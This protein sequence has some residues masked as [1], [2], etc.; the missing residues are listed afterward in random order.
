MQGTVEQ[1]HIEARLATLERRFEQLVGPL[2]P[3]A[4][5]VDAAARAQAQPPAG[6]YP[7]SGP[8]PARSARTQDP[9]RVGA[10]SRPAPA[11]LKAGVATPAA[12]PVFRD[13]AA[14]NESLSDL[15]GGR[16][17]A[18]LGGVTTVIGFVLLLALA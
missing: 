14:R 13:R 6:G 2:R 10:A 9:F 17:L 5:R 12:R 4:S 1:M 3:S 11:A 18:W 16:L 7:P 15:V 8:E